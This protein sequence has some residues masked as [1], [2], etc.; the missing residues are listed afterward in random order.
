MARKR[1]SAANPLKTYRKSLIL[2]EKPGHLRAFFYWARLFGDGWVGCEGL[3]ACGRGLFGPRQAHN[4]DQLVDWTK[5]QLWAGRLSGCDS[6][7]RRIFEEYAF[8]SDASRQAALAKAQHPW[9]RL[10][11]LSTCSRRWCRPRSGCARRGPRCRRWPMFP[12]KRL[13][14]TW[15][16]GQGQC[17]GGETSE[18]G[19]FCPKSPSCPYQS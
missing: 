3:L 10:W 8:A 6:R 4:D 13:V 1:R 2:L 16:F 19:S 18:C 5:R 7:V 14:G 11:G 15:P 12:F 17:T 9:K